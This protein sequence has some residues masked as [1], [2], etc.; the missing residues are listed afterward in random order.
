MSR[1]PLP[2]GQK[3]TLLMMVKFRP[4]VL[5]VLERSR[6]KAEQELGLKDYYGKPKRLSWSAYARHA[7]WEFAKWHVSRGDPRTP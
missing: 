6:A 3:R 4:Q 2:I 1:K 5:E 7:I